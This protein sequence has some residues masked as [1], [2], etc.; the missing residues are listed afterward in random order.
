ME[1]PD[2]F[3]RLLAPALL[4]VALLALGACG[5]DDGMT[6]PPPTGSVEVTA[7]TTGSSLD[8]DG[9]M[10]AVAG[11]ASQ[12]IGL[13]ATVTAADVATGAQSVELTDVAANCTVAGDNPRNV[14]VTD[15]ATV[16]T[17]FVVTCAPV[18]SVEITT[19][20]TGDE[21]DA[22]GYMVSVAGGPAEAIEVS[23]SLTV[24]L[25]AAGS[26]SVELTDVASNCTVAGDNPRDV[27]VVADGTASTQ[28]DVTCFAPISGQIV[29][30]TDRD[31]DL[32]V[33]VMDEDGSNP[34][35]LTNH[36]TTDAIPA[37]SPDGTKIAFMSDRDGNFEIYVVNADGSDP[38]NLTDNLAND[39]SPAWSPDGSQLLF[40]SDRS[41]ELQVYVMNADGSGVTN[42]TNMP[43][44]GNGF[45]D[46]SPDGSQIVFATGRDGDAEIYVMNADG[47]GQTNLTNDPGEDLYPTWSPDGSQ[48]AFT[49]LR[50]GAG[51][52]YVMNADGSGQTNLTN[53]AATDQLA[54]W[55]PDGTQIAFTTFRD[56]DGEIYVMNADGSGP[57]NLS[58]APASSEN[59]GYP[60]GWR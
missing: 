1:N 27:N 45:A 54:S 40:T 55:S 12:A 36:P 39:Q 17:T 59:I 7:A 32:E 4:T 13:N 57:T 47:S 50:G 60:G 46:W 37:V 5:D 16:T 11:G 23:A 56:G 24:D 14:T 8:A 10:V 18:G 44:T 22:D 33:Y 25:V 29:F 2:R 38:V 52:I 15:G 42:L 28:F 51:E 35:N 26:Q 43:G 30:H 31:G 20:T 3:E 21:V 53:N 19:V 34:I 48:I 49:T 58:S 41:G 6:G 9:Y